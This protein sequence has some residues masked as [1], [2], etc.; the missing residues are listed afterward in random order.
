MVEVQTKSFLTIDRVSVKA[1]IELLQE[2]KLFCAEIQLCNLDCFLVNIATKDTFVIDDK[3]ASNLQQRTH[4]M[5]SY[6]AKSD[7]RNSSL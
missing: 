2:V 1:D 4:V 7:R 6:D 3:S 5:F